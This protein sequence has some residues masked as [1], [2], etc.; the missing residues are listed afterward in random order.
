MELAV[1]VN[2]GVAWRRHDAKFGEHRT[3]IRINEF[4]DF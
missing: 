4:K 2:V 3:D 1:R